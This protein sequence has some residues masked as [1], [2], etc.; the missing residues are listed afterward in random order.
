ML[1]LVAEPEQVE[2]RDMKKGGCLNV[3]QGPLKDSPFTLP[4]ALLT[5]PIL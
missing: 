3:M 2:C 1:R 5:C 4:E